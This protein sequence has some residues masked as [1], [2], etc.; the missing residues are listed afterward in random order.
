MLID[1]SANR[2]YVSGLPFEHSSAN[3]IATTTVKSHQPGNQFI[4]APKGNA[5]TVHNSSNFLDRHYTLFGYTIIVIS[6]LLF[7]FSDSLNLPDVNSQNHLNHLLSGAV[8]GL[9][10]PGRIST[11]GSLPVSS[12]PGSLLVRL[13]HSS[14]LVQ[15]VHNICPSAHWRRHELKESRGVPFNLCCTQDFACDGLR[16]PRIRPPILVLFPR[17]PLFPLS[18]AFQTNKSDNLE[19]IFVVHSRR[20]APC[21]QASN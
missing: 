10:L 7:L 1:Q 11:R 20:P 3:E 18:T 8:V 19:A 4:L 2:A 16:Y 21:P 12:S 14:R 5:S 6:P 9:A 13:S 15:Q 17:T